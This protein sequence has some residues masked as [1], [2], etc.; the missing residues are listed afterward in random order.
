MRSVPGGGY[1]LLMKYYHELRPIDLEQ[2]KKENTPATDV[3]Y[4]KWE[5]NVKVESRSERI[6]ETNLVKLQDWSRTIV[7]KFIEV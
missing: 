1:N 3:R 5:P 2:P 6:M 4:K 7:W